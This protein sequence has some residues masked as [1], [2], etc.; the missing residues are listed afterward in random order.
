[1]LNWRMRCGEPGIHKRDGFLRVIG[2]Q[3]I[4]STFTRR[5]SAFKNLY[6]R[7][8]GGYRRSRFSHTKKAEVPYR[9]LRL[10]H[11]PIPS[12]SAIYLP[13]LP[14]PTDSNIHRRISD[15]RASGLPSGN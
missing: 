6:R 4:I 7:S 2:V 11:V 8:R 15:D 5:I 3:E 10:L 12:S 9:G 13:E 14:F 1:M